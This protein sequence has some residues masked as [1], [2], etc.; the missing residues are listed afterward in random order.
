MPTKIITHHIC[1]PIPDRRCD[2]SAVTDDYDGAPDSS[3]RHQIGFG[4]TEQEAI[5]DLLE[6]IDGG[7]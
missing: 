1:P 3:N 4:R 7:A 6:Q 2:W 5:D